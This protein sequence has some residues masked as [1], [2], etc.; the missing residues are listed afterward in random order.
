MAE[1]IE[2]VAA[3]DTRVDPEEQEDLARQIGED[4]ADA[5]VRYVRGELPFEDLTFL[6]HDALQDAYFIARG[7]YEV[8][9]NDEAW[10]D[11]EEGYDLAEATSEQE[12]LAQE[13]AR[14]G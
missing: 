12:D 1:D 3:E 11:D 8:S 10:D 2:D 5:F 9:E 13:P 14:D 6:T 7:A 4:L